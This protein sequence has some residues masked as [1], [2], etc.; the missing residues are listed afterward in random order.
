VTTSAAPCRRGRLISVEGLNGVGKTYLTS[1]L[2]QLL[3]GRPPLVLEEFA[4]R[5]DGA[6]DLG[7]VI[8]GTLFSEAAG[9]PFLR[10]GHPGAETLALLA[11]KMFDFERCRAS[12]AA[13]RLVLEGRSVHSTAVY[14]SLIC[15]P[16]DENAAYQQARALLDLAAA[17]R[18]MPDLTIL[19]ADDTDIAIGRAQRRDGRTYTAEQ[20]R[21]HERAARRDRPR[22][23]P[24]GRHHRRSAAAMKTTP[25]GCPAVPALLDAYLHRRLP[26]P[27]HAIL[28]DHLD[29]C[30]PCWAIWNRYRWDAAVGHPLVAALHDFLGSSYRPYLDSSRALHDEWI[31]AQPRTTAEIRHFFENSEAYLYNLV[32]WHASGN[33]PGYVTA[34]APY[35]TGARIILDFGSGIGQD[36]I[37]LRNLGHAVLPCDLPCPSARFMGYRLRQAGHDHRVA[38]ADPNDDDSHHSGSMASAAMI[39]SAPTSHTGPPRG[40]VRRARRRAA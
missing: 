23:D 39:R 27:G 8:V 40:R 20:R 26:D 32:I 17:W 19:I 34:A 35:L 13:G 15:H 30:Q 3:A 33:R 11:V 12:L 14:Q 4:A 7:R 28:R 25:T 16:A 31:A 37:D 21:M 1:T 36:T 5:S 10:S 22:A 38:E 2:T 24:A 29:S 9:D 6:G 18:P